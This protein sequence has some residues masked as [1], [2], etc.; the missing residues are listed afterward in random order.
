[1]KRVL[2]PHPSLPV[3]YLEKFLWSVGL[4]RPVWNS[5]TVPFIMDFDVLVKT[6]GCIDTPTVLLG[7]CLR[8]FLII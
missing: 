8:P 3:A 1:M 5:V 2:P 6:K 4:L 7:V